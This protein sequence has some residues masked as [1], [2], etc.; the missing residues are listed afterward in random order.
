MSGDVR[1]FRVGSF[2]AAERRRGLARSSVDK[3]VGI[4][5]RFVEAVGDPFEATWRDV[6]RFV[7]S[8]NMTA[9]SSRYAA[10]SHLHAFYVWAQRVELTDTDPTILVVRPRIPPAAPRP[11]HSTDVA[12]ALTVAT[13]PMRAAVALAALCGLR[14]IE[15]A[16]LRWVDVE[17]DRVRVTGKG[18]RVRVIPLPVAVR[19]AL[20]D[21]DR[22]VAYVL[23]GWQGGDR[24]PGRI[25]SRRIG[26]FF[27]SIGST[28]TAHE[29]RHY[30]ATTALGACGDLAAV[31]D[32]LG[33][34]SPVTT[35]IYAR[36]DP[37]RL[38]DV[39]AA[40]TVPNG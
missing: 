15:L 31:Q 24:A 10:V 8:T 1:S 40:M 33:H 14:C 37:R 23:D 4:V 12:L 28:T 17:V 11:A 3:R 13:G 25:A 2:E 6:E 7:D 34:A 20:D 18:S 27:R 32:W 35:R 9:P 5:R 19:D 36:L 39:A 29:L 30:C 22:A 16:S 21:L 26:A 38:D